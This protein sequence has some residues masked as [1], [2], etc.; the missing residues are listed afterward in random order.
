MMNLKSL[1]ELLLQQCNVRTSYQNRLQ[2]ML[3]MSEEWIP[4]EINQHL[5][6][7]MTKTA[8]QALGIEGP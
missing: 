1:Q 5:K 6:E 3:Q 4:T 7:R 2:S 8:N